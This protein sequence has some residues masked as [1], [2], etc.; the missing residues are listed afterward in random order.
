LG[1]INADGGDTNAGNLVSKIFFIGDVDVAGSLG[2]SLGG[3][4]LAVLVVVVVRIV[5]LAVES[6]LLAVDDVFNGNIWPATIAAVASSAAVDDVGFGEGVEGLV[7]DGPG[8]FDGLDGGEGPARA[9]LCLVLDWVDNSFLTP[10]PGVWIVDG[11]LLQVSLFLLST[12]A[13]TEEGFVFGWGEVGK[14][15]KADFEGCSLSIVFL[16]ET[17][18]RKENT[19]AGLV[20]FASEGKTVFSHVGKEGFFFVRSKHFKK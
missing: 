11:F 9:A 4:E 18:S 14:L 12:I 19:K 1:G 8:G 17:L 5:F 10:V 16:D 7:C 2:I 3:V 20:F 13:D 15:V 6:T